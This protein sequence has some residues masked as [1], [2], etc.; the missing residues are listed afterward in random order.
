[1]ENTKKEKKIFKL[2]MEKFKRK[3]NPGRGYY[4]TPPKTKINSANTNFPL[5]WKDIEVMKWGGTVSSDTGQ[6]VTLINTCTIVTRK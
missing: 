4:Q 3:K 1:M 2:S 5:Q 6:Q